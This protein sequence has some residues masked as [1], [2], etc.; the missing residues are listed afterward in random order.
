MLEL[1]LG[2]LRMRAQSI[3]KKYI[4]QPARFCIKF[5]RTPED[6]N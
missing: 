1:N 5:L 2:P 4:D 6:E 3:V